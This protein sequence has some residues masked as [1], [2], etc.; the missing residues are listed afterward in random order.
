MSPTAPASPQRSVALDAVRAVAVIAMVIGHTLDA[1]LSPAARA[2]HAVQVYWEFRGITAPLFLCVAGW[3]MTAA[4]AR[5]GRSGMEVLRRYLPR[6]ALLLACGVALRW[7]GWD[8]WGLVTFQRPVWEHLLAFDA[9]H[10]VAGGV[11]LAAL[12]FA[13][14]PPRGARALRVGIALSILV[15]FPWVSPALASWMP[16]HALALPLSEA[17]VSLPSPFPLFPW[18]AY[19]FCGVLLREAL[20]AARKVHP[21]VVAVG[22]GLVVMGFLYS[23]LGGLLREDVQ[24][25][26]WRMALMFPVAGVALLLPQSVATRLAPVGRASLWAYVLHLPIAYGWSTYPGLMARVGQTLSFGQG[27]LLALGVLAVS[28][29]AALWAKRHVSPLKKRL[30]ERLFE[31]EGSPAV[32]PEFSPHLS[33]PGADAHS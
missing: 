31:T 26:Y 32:A 7:P 11:L 4:I 1:T 18:A 17:L 28:V 5:S 29:T 27:F 33:R 15:L 6:V 13:W 14:L 23:P 20:E 21:A 8:L 2:A 10:C 24:Q 19:F 16:K 9:L 3:A 30:F 12:L 25:F 22:M